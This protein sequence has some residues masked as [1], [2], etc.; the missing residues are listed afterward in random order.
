[1][2]VDCVS[3]VCPFCGCGCGIN[4]VVK[5]GRIVGV[6][7]WKEH[8]V[9]EGKNCIKGR[10]AYG[11]LYDD[12]RLKKP[13]V[14]KNGSFEEVSW[15]EALALIAEKLGK[16][17]PNSVGFINSG[18][19]TNEDLYVMQK[20]ARVI[21]KTNNI[22][23]AS[24]FCHST[25]VPAL[26]ST[27]GSGVMSTSEISVGEADCIFIAG[28]NIKETYPLISRRILM[29]RE[30]G[31]KIILS[32]PRT[33]VTATTLADIH[34]PLNAG[35]DVALVNA[36][37]KVILDEG[38]E[39]KEFIEKR[40]SGFDELKKKLSSFDLNE[41]E[42]ITGIPVEKIKEA[43]TIYAKAQ[44]SCILFNAGIAQ[45]YAGV[46]NIIALADLA[47]ITGNY[48]KPGTG[49]NP[50]RGHINGE[51]FGDMGPVPAFYPGFKAVNEE[52]AKLFEGYWGVEGLPSK[53]GL[54]YM[55]MVEQC[56]V[57]YI[58]GAN[59]MMSAPDTNRV[60]NLLGEK[61]FIVVQ[62]IFMTETAE[63]ADVVLPAAT[64]VEKGGT[65]TEVDRRVQRINKAI[66]PPGEAKADWQVLC[67][68]A[69]VMGFKEKFAFSSPEEIFE[70]I[71]KYV[72]QY[73]GIT[74]ERLK[75]AGGIQW[76]CP[77]EDH[78]GTNTMFVE[79]FSTP[80]GLGHLQA[81]EYQNPA[82]LPDA[83][84]PYI[85]TNGR[86]MFHYH[87][88]TMTRKV[89]KLASEVPVA[90]VQI[91]SDDAREKGIKRGDRVTLQS[92]RGQITA[93]ARPDDSIKKGMLFM[94][95]HFSESSANILTGPS[96]GPPSKMP[97]FKFC[98]VKLEKN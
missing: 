33:T 93:I 4:L 72:P 46:E 59:T 41:A 10:N 35:T 88:G 57:L 3:T 91:N 77:S 21:T 23:N 70:E 28:V 40:T 84:F 24:R 44:K 11:F 89:A 90:M 60:K 42:K 73:A 36:M 98:A 94:P 71:R 55:D 75:Q 85:F 20:F 16:A 26:M 62:D 1:M 68:L 96:A 34:L 50:L 95:W 56:K 67:E 48:G 69:G 29:A 37:M 61:D 58:M 86:V 43:A 49:V 13:M 17:E 54:T 79:K 66:E 52:S 87:S 15:E 9:N 39:D 63:L 80:D 51:G 47:L 38:L 64:W 25:S 12:S 7:P 45:H 32:D 30:K 18:K 2:Q 83:D 27:V 82:E 8:P 92:R 19:C 65:T 6:E 97:E 74:Y 81:V 76:P 22:D 78:P 31:A 14:K 5:D 53:T